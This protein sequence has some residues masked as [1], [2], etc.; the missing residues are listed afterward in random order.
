MKQIDEAIKQR[1]EA[2]KQR[3]GVIKQRDGVIKHRDE[4]INLSS[5]NV[6]GKNQKKSGFTMVG[7]VHL[8]ASAL[9]FA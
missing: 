9:R 3:D 8:G 4:V 1:D 7:S 6:D 5:K 2:I